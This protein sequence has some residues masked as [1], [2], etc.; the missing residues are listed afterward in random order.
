MYITTITH[1][2]T[3][4]EQKKKDFFFFLL[5]QTQFISTT[6]VKQKRFHNRKKTPT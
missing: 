6:E 2:Q 1:H 3:T 4:K 5:F